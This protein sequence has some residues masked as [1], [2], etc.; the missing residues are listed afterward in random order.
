MNTMAD[1]TKNAQ[2]VIALHAS[3]NPE[4]WAPTLASLSVG[5]P[6]IPVVVA[7]PE[8]C[9]IRT[10]RGLAE[11]YEMTLESAL[12]PSLDQLVGA[13][14]REF[15]GHVLVITAPVVVPP[16][17]LGP[18][19]KLADSELRCA[20]VSF[21]SNTADY[22]SFP[23]RGGGAIPEAAA[24]EGVA[25]DETVITRRLRLR[26]AALSP[27]PIP[28]AAGP[29]VLISKQGLSVVGPP[30]I[31]G[32]DEPEL[33]L[34]EYSARARAHGMVDY[35]DPSTFV[36]RL[37]DVVDDVRRRSHLTPAEA[38]SL[39][40][41][42]PALARAPTES[43]EHDG[44][45]ADVLQTARAAVLGLRVIIDATCLGP[46]EMGTQ[47]TVLALIEALA[48][49][50]EV[51]Y[52]GVA[53]AGPIPSYAEGKLSSPK[54]HVRV[55]ADGDFTR[56]PLAD[57]VH[58]PYQPSPGIR[59]G[60][61]R[62][63]GR[64]TLVTMLD[65]IAYQ[66]PGYHDSADAWFKYRKIVRSACS[67]VDGVIVISE[68]VREA[69][70]AERLAVDPERVFVVP[71]GT[72]HLRG[73]EAEVMPEELLHRGFTG[74]EFL[75][76]LGADYTHKNRDLAIRT[77]EALVARGHELAL[78]MAGA[79]VPRGSS[80]VA[81]A[82]AWSPHL[83][84]Y[85]VPTVTSAERN[86]LLRHASL[87]LYPTGAEGFGLVPDEAAAFGTPSVFVPFGPFAERYGDLP[88]LPRVWTAEAFAD[89]AEVLL[90]EPSV[91][92]DQVAAIAEHSRGQ[93]D[94]SAAARSTVST[95]W[96]LLARPPHSRTR[97][98]AERSEESET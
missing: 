66:V 6:G 15:D 13:V 56:F 94:W 69:I 83:R 46:W 40:A 49:Q 27:I 7:G 72:S 44:G 1:A 22:L 67:V 70:A 12:V 88:G 97:F 62:K 84:V 68:N 74:D 82:G 87:V 85:V 91:A 63:A 95:Y 33:L 71:T 29:A 10:L 58:R 75:L 39:H 50:P 86:W 80:R 43:S 45:L 47:V 37:H 4:L 42:A 81:E 93:Y 26:T 28:Y 60:S 14:G 5:C 51:S 57:V 20:S 25:F 61:W 55:V 23:A 64:R 78:V 3:G 24:F 52:V 21:L 31:R 98:V 11:R 65:L 38:A 35:L 2:A 41:Q 9:A 19:L 73:D 77:L 92:R 32:P 48:D 8:P 16:H 54:V 18:A 79:H 96:S 89:A 90:A 36:T 76:V 17:M 53:V 59:L 34:G 30:S